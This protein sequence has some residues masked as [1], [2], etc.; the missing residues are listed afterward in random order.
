MFRRLIAVALISAAPSLAAA[1]SPADI[2][3]THDSTMCATVHSMMLDH[4]QMF[5]LDSAQMDAIHAA[6][7]TA[8]AN[9]ASP[10]SVHRAIME[11]LVQRVGGSDAVMQHI[12]EYM[13]QHMAQMPLDSAHV[14]AIHACFAG[15]AGTPKER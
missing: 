11:T 2:P 14:A 5:G 12:H 3:A 1:Q 6:A 15:H 10:D 9:G 13:Q 7:H 8:I 4:A